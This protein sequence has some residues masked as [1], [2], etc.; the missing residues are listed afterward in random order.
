M[1]FAGDLTRFLFS[2]ALGKT[3]NPSGPTAANLATFEATFEACTEL[4]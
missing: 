1:F 4:S 3:F 2:L